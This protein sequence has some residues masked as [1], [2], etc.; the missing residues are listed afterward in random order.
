M[1]TKASEGPI[2]TEKSWSASNPR[3][4]ALMKEPESRGREPSQRR[5]PHLHSGGGAERRPRSGDRKRWCERVCRAVG[6]GDRPAWRR[7]HCGRN[8]SHA[9]RC[10]VRWAVW[11]HLQ[12]SKRKVP[13]NAAGRLPSRG[14]RLQSGANGSIF[15]KLL[16]P[17]HIR[18]RCQSLQQPGRDLSETSFQH[19]LKG[20]TA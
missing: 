12:A 10:R 2:L 7:V 15:Q 16:K 5:K 17:L 3:I 8:R 14:E 11:P 19:V 1:S 9:L 13:G 18:N 20:L 4:W 6:A